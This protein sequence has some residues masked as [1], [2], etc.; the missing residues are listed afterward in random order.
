[1]TPI[2]TAQESEIPSVDWLGAPLDCTCCTVRATESDPPVRCEAGHACVQDRYARRIDR[3][4][5]WNPQQGNA[6]LAHPYFEVRAIACRHA[7]VFRL[8][9]LV[10]DEDETVRLS[11]ALRLPLAQAARMSKDPHREVRIRVAMRLDG[12]ALMAMRDD[13]DYYVRKLV[14]RNAPAALLPRLMQDPDA[15]VRIEVARRLQMPELL[16][17]RDDPEVAVRREVVRRLPLALLASMAGDPA[18][19]VRCELLERADALLVARLAREDGEPEVRTMAARR[20]QELAATAAASR[21]PG[22]G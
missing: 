16:A 15:E 11:V 12:S 20:L 13:P 2:V 4:F 19:E 21:G 9:P 8:Q 14:A 22:H 18:W 1:M 3:F 10:E 6:W 7:D 5:R 17:L